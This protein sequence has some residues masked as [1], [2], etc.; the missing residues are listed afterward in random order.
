MTR[1]CSQS[2]SLEAAS[3]AT[4]FLERACQNSIQ[5]HKL[6]EEFKEHHYAII[7]FPDEESDAWSKEQDIL[8][9]HEEEE[10]KL[11]VRYNKLV[12]RA[13]SADL[14]L[15]IKQLKHFEEQ[16]INLRNFINSSSTAD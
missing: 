7:D 11:L 10:S 1:I 9:A 14:K 13:S 15:L 4:D 3:E 8:Y 16:L 2:A 6:T 5:L 12:S